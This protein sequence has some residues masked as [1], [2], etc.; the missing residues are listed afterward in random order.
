MASTFFGLSIGKSGLYASQGGLTTTAHNIANTETEGFT[1]QTVN[2]QASRALR[3]NSTYGMAGT[4][5]DVTGVTQARDEYYD[6]KYRSNNMVSGSYSTKAYY[7]TEIENYFNEITLEGFTTTYNDMYDALQELDKNPSD[8]SVRTNLTNLSQG[9]CEYFNSLYNSLQSIQENCNTEIQTQVQRVNSIG[10]QIAILSRQINTIEVGGGSANDLRDQRELL[11]DELSNYANVTIEETLVGDGVGINN[12]VVKINNQVLIDG[13]SANTL[14]CVPRTDKIN[15]TDAR[16][17]YEIQWANGQAY[18]SG[19]GTSGGTLKAILDVR[20][21]NNNEAFKG[22]LE[23]AESGDLTV[24]ITATNVN[25]MD[26][27]SIPTNG[28]L[29]IG[30]REYQYNGFAVK[31]DEDT[32]EY[33]YE[34][35]LN[36]GLVVDADNTKVSIGENIDYKGIPYYMSQMSQF[37]RTL[38]KSF[39][40]ISTS[41]V[42]LYGNEGLD[43]FNGTDTSSGKNYVFGTSETDEYEGYLFTSKTGSYEAEE[44]TNYGSYYLLTAG[45]ICIT[46]DLIQ[47]PSLVVTASDITD[48]VEESNLVSQYI[49]LKE[50]A[51][52]FK[53]GT[54]SEFLNA[55]VAEIGID[56][57]KAKDFATNQENILASVKNQRLSVSGVDAEEE[58]MNLIRYQNAYELSS[59]VISVLNEIYDKLIN[60]TGV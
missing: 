8:L 2:Q 34:F 26:D 40:D 16:G 45:N 49:A 22:N 59:K 3:V 25:N 55:L 47:D 17:L 21:G 12:Y 51:S 6:E 19:T 15:Q 46:K 4:G 36:E 57:A 37:V 20:D 44:E 28:V 58:A 33:I 39:N 48:G 23:S 31:T 32:G 41:G 35:S 24:T 53:Q 27:L 42:D 13:Y 14:K 10:Q 9:L 56:S 1:R 29:T 38:A 5:V 18:N 50:D 43:F 60:G 54:V 11:V 7:M 52:L 30:N